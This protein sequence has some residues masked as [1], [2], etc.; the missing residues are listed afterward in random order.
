MAIP[1]IDGCRGRAAPCSRLRTA[2]GSAPPTSPGTTSHGPRPPEI[3]KHPPCDVRPDG[4]AVAPLPRSS[5]RQGAEPA[6]TGGVRRCLRPGL[7]QRASL[8]ALAPCDDDRPAPE[9]H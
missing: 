9:P 3:A 8:L 1:E 5:P 4:S 7:L 6:G 2:P